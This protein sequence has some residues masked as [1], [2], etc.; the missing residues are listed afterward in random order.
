MRE[1]SR[2]R[3]EQVT[4]ADHLRTVPLAVSHMSRRRLSAAW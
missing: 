1:L 3:V 2:F 4:A